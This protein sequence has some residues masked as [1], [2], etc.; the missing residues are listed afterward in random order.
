[1]RKKSNE[2]R[3]KMRNYVCLHVAIYKENRR[4]E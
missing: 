2:D 4:E 3:E 1:M